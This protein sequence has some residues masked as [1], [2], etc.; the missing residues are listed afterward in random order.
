MTQKYWFSA[1]RPG[2]GWGWGPPFT[3][4]GWLVF[5]GFLVFLI[6]GGILLIPYGEHY[7]V[8]YTFVLAV[9]L[10]LICARKGEPPGRFPSGKR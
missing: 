10:M 8:A 3:W 5:V 2:S 9:I 4:Q 6:G 7:F 1:K